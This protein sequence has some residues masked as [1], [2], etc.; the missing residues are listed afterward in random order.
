MDTILA[1]VSD[2]MFTVKILDA[3]KASGRK[4]RFVKSLETALHA[5]R[6]T[7]PPLVVV[8]LNCRDFDTL[9]LIRSM[10]TDPDLASIRTLGFLSHVQEGRKQEAIAA[11]CDQV[12]PRSVFSDRTGV[13]L[14]G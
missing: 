13:L 10:K 8:D 7:R 14:A 3:A 11:G 6:E 9:D 2:L 12:V 1:A 5:I 4:A